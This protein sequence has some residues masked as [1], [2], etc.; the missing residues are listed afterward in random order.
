M[1]SEGPDENSLKIMYASPSLVGKKVGF[2]FIHPGGVCSS[3]T[4][5][6]FSLDPNRLA[7]LLHSLSVRRSFGLH[8]SM[9]RSGHAQ[10]VFSVQW[11]LHPLST[12]P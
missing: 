1:L 4:T 2:P 11:S 3:L 8:A 5:C 7:A 12:Y 10:G 9:L 6:T